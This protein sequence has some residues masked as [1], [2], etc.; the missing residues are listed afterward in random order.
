M[1]SRFF[2]DDDAAVPEVEP[3]AGLDA[4]TLSVE[5]ELVARLTGRKESV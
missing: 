5:V 2:D 3:T 1:Y 4:Y